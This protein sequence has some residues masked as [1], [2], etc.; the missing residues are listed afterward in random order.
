[1]FAPERTGRSIGPSFIEHTS[2]RGGG[3]GA[4]IIRG[5]VER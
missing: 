5:R 2:S 4:K 1:M 3:E